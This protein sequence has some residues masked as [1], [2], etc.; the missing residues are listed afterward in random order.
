LGVDEVSAV[1]FDAS[2][3]ARE[4]THALLLSKDSGDGD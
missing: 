2:P 3:E 4:R 1:V